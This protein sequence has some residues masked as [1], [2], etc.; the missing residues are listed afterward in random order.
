MRSFGRFISFFDFLT[1]ANV[2]GLALG[3]ML[4]TAITEISGHLIDDIVYPL[5]SPIIRALH[6]DTN[7]KFRLSEGVEI[8]VSNFSKSFMKFSI[9]LLIVGALVKIFQISL[10]PPVMGVSIVK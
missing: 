2:F 9:I 5:L 8:D 3:L 10:T 1:Q 6:L 4:G 7:R